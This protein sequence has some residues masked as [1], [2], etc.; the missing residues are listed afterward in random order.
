MAI[1][2][3]TTSDYIVNGPKNILSEWPSLQQAGFAYIDAVLPNPANA[4]EAYFFCGE[5]Y[6]LI[7]IKPCKIVNVTHR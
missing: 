5:Q 7:N 1:P 3:C 4:E 6:A 2:I